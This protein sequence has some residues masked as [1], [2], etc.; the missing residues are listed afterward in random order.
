MKRSLLSFFFLVATAAPIIAA[1]ISDARYVRISLPGDDR[2]LTLAEVE[3]TSGGKNVAPKGEASQSSTAHRGVAERAIDGNKDPDYHQRGQ[4]HTDGDGSTAPW[5]EL[6]LREERPVERVRIWNRGGLH[7]RLKGFVLEL[8]DAD[9][10]RVFVRENNP[11]PDGSITFDLEGGTEIS[12]ADHDGNAAPVPILPDPVPEDYRDPEPFAFRRGDTVAMI[13]NGL[14]DRMQHHGWTETLL[15]ASHPELELVFRNMSVSGDRIDH[16]PR[17]EGF[18]PMNDYLRHVG[19]DVIFAFF[20]Y[21]ESFAGSAGLP[22]FEKRLAAMI[23]RYRGVKPNGEDFPRI[24]LFSPIA[25]EDLDDPNLPDGSENNRRLAL[26][27]ASMQKVAGNEGVAFVDLFGPTKKLY[28]AHEKP[29]TLDGVHLEARGYRLLGEVIADALGDGDVAASSEHE[30]IR[31]AVLDKNWHWHNRYRAT[32]GN[33]IWGG[34]S[35]LK[36]VDGQTNAEVLQHELTMLDVMTANRDPR[37]WARAR[38]SEW[39]VEDDDVP[40]PIPV[41]SNVGGGSKSSNPKKEGSLDYISGEEGLD[42]MTVP[43]GFEVNLF[44]DEQTFPELVNP[45]QMQVDG[46]GRLWVAAWKT[47]PKW[48][49][50]REMDDRLLILPDDDGDG[51]ADRCVTFAK[52]HSPLG[53]EFWNG[54]VVVTSQPDILFLKDTDGDDKADVRRIL[55]QGIGSSDTHHAANNLI[56]G[57]GGGIY[58]QSGIFLQHNHEHPWGPSLESTASGMYRLDPRRHTIAFHAENRPNPHGI[59]FDGWGYHYANDGTSGRAWQVLP[60]EDGFTM[61]ELLQ[62]EVRPVPAN[63]VVSSTNFPESMQ[64]DFLICNTIGFLGIKQYDLHRDGYSKG[65]KDFDLGEVWGEPKQ[66]LLASSDKNFRPT[67]AVFGGDG[68]LYVSD[69][70]NVIIGHMQHHIRDP[71]RDH[72]H[73]RIY[74]LRYADRPLQEPVPIDDEP[75]S[76]LLRN[77]EHPVAHVR[78]RTRVELSERD[79]GEVIAATKEWLAD[80]DPEKKAHARHFLEAL[81]LHQQHNVRDRELLQTVLASPHPHAVE[82]AATVKHHWDVVDPAKNVVTSP[83]EQTEET[84]EIDVPERFSKAET[85]AYRLGAE[86]FH[87]DA[88]CVTCHQ[89]N[90]QGLPKVYPPLVGSPWVT[91]DPERLTKLTLHGLWGPIEVNGKT[92]DPQKGVPPMTAFKALLDDEELAAVLTYVRNTWGNEASPVAPGL[93]ERVRR[94]TADRQAFYKPAELLEAHPLEE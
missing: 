86:V 15:Q 21:N 10:E 26:Y 44:A 8:L 92:W 85:E 77:L 91:G 49:P 50:G 75:I 35:T 46:K 43:E 71:N 37:I 61:R 28:E 56:F 33:D 11:A 51:V 57:P 19:A 48:E 4:T 17:S 76:S 40:E 42:H 18:T 83:I 27:A 74:R 2:I 58:W 80:F 78:H 39:K 54:G 79:T 94:E 81:W 53:F 12:M 64:G 59:S 90:G 47:Y 93:V 63:E 31:E 60:D 89:P 38:G 52:V 22:E 68:A 34:R 55:L 45:V 1:E 23:E 5:W 24:V 88:H 29:L 14:G 84:L 65:E 25:H 7:S 69:W 41:E 82:A 13:G 6:D 32:D 20:G 3:V 73:G 66:D 36:F 16:Y 30:P 72:R 70:H 87:R 9:R 62:K 67:D